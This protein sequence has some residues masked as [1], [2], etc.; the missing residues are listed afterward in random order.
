MQTCRK[1]TVLARPCLRWAR[2][3][4]DVLISNNKHCGDHP[5]KDGDQDISA[6]CQPGDE[7]CIAEHRDVKVTLDAS[8]L[9]A[10]LEHAEEHALPR[11]ERDVVAAK[12]GHAERIAWA[13]AG[14]GSEHGAPQL[15][16]RARRVSRRGERN[17]QRP[18]GRRELVGAR[19]AF[20]SLDEALGVDGP[21]VGD[22]DARQRGE[23]RE[24]LRER[25]RRPRGGSIGDDA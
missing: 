20:G 11:R 21:A 1:G 13:A 14:H 12:D 17:V 10:E 2:N 5:C 23:Q 9:L 18:R 25:H 19:G 16:G 3:L 15:G 7:K 6:H 22:G 8:H 4:L 24:Q